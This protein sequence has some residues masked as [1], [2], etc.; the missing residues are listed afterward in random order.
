M[1]GLSVQRDT[2]CDG[3]QYEARTHRLVGSWSMAR[4]GKRLQ[5]DQHRPRVPQILR[6]RAAWLIVL[7]A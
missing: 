6:Q 4:N 3:R 7:T 2:A 5:Q 1:R